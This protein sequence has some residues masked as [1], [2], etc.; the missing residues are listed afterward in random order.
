MDMNRT[1]QSNTA[2]AEIELACQHNPEVTATAATA[3]M[4]TS[5]VETVRTLTD[6]DHLDQAGLV[7]AIV[8]WHA[9]ALRAVIPPL[10]FVEK[11]DAFLRLADGNDHIRPEL[12]GIAFEFIKM[13][14]T[15]EA[16]LRDL[17]DAAVNVATS[18][19]DR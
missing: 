6:T 10:Y 3:A 2:L 8:D 14:S 5:L 13:A 15:L 9:R 7:L 1:L 19:S 18:E 4:M 11:A 17:R 12:D 16:A